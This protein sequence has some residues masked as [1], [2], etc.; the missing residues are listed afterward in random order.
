MPRPAHPRRLQPAATGYNN[1]R[2]Q[3]PPPLPPTTTVAAG[4]NNHCR[5]R[6]HYRLIRGAMASHLLPLITPRR[7]PAGGDESNNN[8][9]EEQRSSIRGTMSRIGMLLNPPHHNNLLATP[10]NHRMRIPTSQQGHE[11]VL[12]SNA[13]SPVRIRKNRAASF[14]QSSFGPSPRRGAKS[15]QRRVDETNDGDLQSNDHNGDY[16]VIIEQWHAYSSNGFGFLGKPSTEFM[17][18]RRLTP[19]EL[20]HLDVGSF[21]L[22]SIPP[23]SRLD[24][25]DVVKLRTAFTKRLTEAVIRCKRNEF[26]DNGKSV[27]NRA[28]D[29]LYL[30]NG[31]IRNGCQYIEIA[32]V[33]KNYPHREEYICGTLSENEV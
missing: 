7:S 31:L 16:D 5:R 25:K 12:T 13:S 9:A 19:N 30:H 20:L 8:N 14:I 22:L 6:L 18:W 4:Y 26:P 15:K 21:F 23:N 29:Y 32:C 1:R 28:I 24:D 27:T 11:L 10:L 2:L 3:Q 33:V 17:G